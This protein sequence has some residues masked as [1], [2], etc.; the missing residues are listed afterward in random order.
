MRIANSELRIANL[1]VLRGSLAQTAPLAAEK[2]TMAGIEISPRYIQELLGHG[3][4]KTT[5]RYTHVS[6]K[7]MGN[8]RSPLDKMDLG[9]EGRETQKGGAL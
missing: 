5:E 8:I 9:G 1:R 7:A 2:E 4:I 6:Q 3:S